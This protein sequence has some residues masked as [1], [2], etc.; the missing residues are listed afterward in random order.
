MCAYDMEPS[1]DSKGLSNA[2][3][4]NRLDT[5]ALQPPGEGRRACFTVTVWLGASGHI[6]GS[7]GR[8][9][10]YET[11]EDRPSHTSTPSA[12]ASAI[13][14]SPIFGAS[15]IFD[16]TYDTLGVIGTTRPE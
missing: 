15:G 9:S 10:I 11:K 6:R 7:A 14:R 13:A 12:S 8:Y 1:N 16:A 3:G 4:P 5:R 2:A